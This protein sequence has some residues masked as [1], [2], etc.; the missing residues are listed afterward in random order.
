[1]PTNG[2]LG[3]SPVV[4]TA[5]WAAKTPST[6]GTIIKSPHDRR[7]KSSPDASKSRNLSESY[8]V[9]ARLRDIDVKL[10]LRHIDVVLHPVEDGSTVSD[11]TMARIYLS[12]T[13]SSCLN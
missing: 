4:T 13:A 9:N 8:F 5:S 7:Q 12:G 11:D 2:S 1:M 6:R 3:T 10:E